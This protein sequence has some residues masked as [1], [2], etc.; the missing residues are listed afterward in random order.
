MGGRPRPADASRRRR[1]ETARAQAV[2]AGGKSVWDN[3]GFYL[4]YDVK[5]ADGKITKT[6]ADD[7]W[8]ADAVEMW[9]DPL[10]LKEK[11]RSQSSY[12]FWAWVAG[13]A[14]DPAKIGGEAIIFP[15]HE[16]FTTFGIDKIQTASKKTP[17]GWSI[18]VHIPSRTLQPFR[19][20][21]ISAR[22]HRRY[23][24]LN[25]HG[26]FPLLLLGWHR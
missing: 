26:H 17:D 16:D 5:D 23:E 9:V 8:E 13:A 3:T 21:R 1:G 15:N 18:E 19:R 7:F 11:H 6:K 25:L 4:A 10:N 24:F 14:D 20:N 22:P 12:Q 2:P